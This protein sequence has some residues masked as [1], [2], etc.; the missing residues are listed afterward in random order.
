[1]GLILDLAVAA[2]ALV[3]IGSLATLAWTLAVSAV[4]ATHRGRQRV[5]ARRRQVAD[6]EA[7]LP[8]LAAR[9]DAALM[10]AIARSAAGP[11]G[12]VHAQAEPASPPIEETPIT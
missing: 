8:V 5:A 11:D 10:A 2:L 12:R 1:M 7:R 3:V 6:A 9:A 4:R